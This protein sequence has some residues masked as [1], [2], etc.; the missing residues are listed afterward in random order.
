LTL[1]AHVG[2]VKASPTEAQILAAF[3]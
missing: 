3:A 2:L 1:S